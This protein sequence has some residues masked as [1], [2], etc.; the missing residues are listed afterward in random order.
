[1]SLSEGFYVVFPSLEEVKKQLARAQHGNVI[2]VCKAILADTE[3]PVSVWM[4]LFRGEKYSF[5]LESVEG[6]DTV[7][8]YS[9]LGGAP[10]LTFTS[11]GISWK[12]AGEKQD[13]G[14]GDPIGVLR[15]LL[16]AYTPVAVEGVPRFCGGAVGYFSYDAVRLR[17]SIPDKNPKEDPLDDIFFGFYR[18]IIAFDNCEHRIL[19]ITNIMLDKGVDVEKAYREAVYRLGGLED[20]MAVRLQA[21]HLSVRQKGEPKSNFTKEGFEAAVEKCRQYISAGDVFQ[22]VPSQRFTVEVDADPFDLYRILRVIN[23]SPYMYYCA[24]DG[25]SIIGAS[26]EM[27]VRVENGTIEMRPIAGTRPRGKNEAED[28][29]QIQEL[30]ADP[31]ERAEHVM[32]VD[33]GRND[34]G[35]VAR[36]GTVQVEEMMHIE[37]YSHVIHIVSNVHGELA[38]GKD[39][40]DA[41]FSCFPAG[42][43]SGA[44]KI[45]AM[46]IIDELEPVKRGVYGG[47]LGYIGW[48]GTMDTCI[49]IR[50]IVYRDGIAT[51]QAGAGI[52]ADSDPGREYQETLQ[53]A[54]ALFAAIRRAAEIAGR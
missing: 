37:K 42:T 6:Q 36:T 27:L 44:P 43:L 22:V 45:R 10:F 46:E 3:T 15:R 28:E 5:L 26:P 38:E 31:K 49:V 24:I 34:V 12:V 9:F 8:R 51:V 47:A 2:P 35:R 32:L 39:S 17:E 25:S 52:V 50:T 11:R 53:K 20:R 54:G 7:A 48:S 23:P 40:F 21:T 14:E 13:K 33:L 41:L 18:D 29:R 1:L 30:L 19:L 4:K 16:S